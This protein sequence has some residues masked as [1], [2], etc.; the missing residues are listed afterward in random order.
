MVDEAAVGEVGA[1]LQAALLVGQVLVQI[2]SEDQ[3][4]GLGR[5]VQS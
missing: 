3:L 2:R 5:I 4:I 1:V